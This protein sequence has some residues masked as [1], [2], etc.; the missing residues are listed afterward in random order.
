MKYLFIALMLQP[1]SHPLVCVSQNIPEDWTIEIIT[2]E[3]MDFWMEVW[4]KGEQR[5]LM[6]RERVT[7]DSCPLARKINE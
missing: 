6:L 2:P 1:H 3:L 7:N 5:I 4:V